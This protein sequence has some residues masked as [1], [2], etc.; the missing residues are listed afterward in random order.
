MT[1]ESITI[2]NYILDVSPLA[3]EEAFNFYYEMMPQYRKE[4]IDSLRR[5]SDKYLSVGA[6]IVLKRI[7]E[8]NGINISEEIDVGKNGKPYIK[9]HPMLQY[10][11]SH[12]GNC[13]FG[14]S[15]SMEVG[16]DIEIDDAANLNVAKR[17]FSDRENAYLLSLP[18]HERDKAFFKLWTLK[19]S[20]VKCV[21]SGFSLPLNKFSVYFENDEVSVEQSIFKDEFAL[22]T[23]RYEDKYT[24]SCCTRYS[25]SCSQPKFSDP[26]KVEI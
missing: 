1:E 10:N 15:G 20:F 16:C 9:S 22:I 21:G 17:F 14:S 25:R 6:G 8:D 23:G 7:C 3:D 18:E 5:K 2:E 19:E 4:K 26:I 11:I 24:Y 13:V 12:S